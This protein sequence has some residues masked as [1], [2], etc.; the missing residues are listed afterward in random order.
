MNAR[1]SDWAAR[2]SGRN[3]SGSEFMANKE[4]EHL[5]HALFVRP[6]PNLTEKNNVR[7]K[8]HP[9]PKS[10]RFPFELESFLF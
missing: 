2:N 6:K 4:G 3:C 9:N 8:K 7:G 1:K 10:H 5:L